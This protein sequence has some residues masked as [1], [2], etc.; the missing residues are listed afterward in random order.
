VNRPLRAAAALAL[1]ALAALALASCGSSSAAEAG[2]SGAADPSGDATLT[3]FAAAS[4]GGSFEELAA[5]F[6]AANPGLEVEFNVAGSSSLV[7]QILA[8]APA[9]VFASADE[10]NMAKVVEAGQAVQPTAFASNVLTLVTPAGNPAGITSLQDLDRRS[11]DG[12]KLVACAPQVPCGNATTAL[13]A[14]AGIELAP[15]SEES[16]V[17]DVLGK[18]VSGEADAGLVYVTDAIGAGEAV[19][20]IELENAEAAVNTYPITVLESSERHG[21]ARQFVDYVLS[22]AGQLL[23]EEY[24]FGAP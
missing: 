14:D 2:S 15:V 5:G 4:L 9:D 10:P 7:E 17:T 18:V 6:E 8:G 3:V 19:H 1:T 21:A 24:G 12:V 13:A 20:T 22:D 16:Q 11:G 23:L